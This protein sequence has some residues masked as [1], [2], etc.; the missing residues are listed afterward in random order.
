MS[1]GAVG[2]IGS[3]ATGQLQ[4]ARAAEGDRA[5]QEV[6]N[7]ARQSDSN[8]RAADAAGIG[9]TERE[10]E[11]SERDADGRRLWERQGKPKPQSNSP[12]VPAEADAPS[13]P[14]SKD[15]SGEAGTQ[16]DLS[17]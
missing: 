8:R 13:A 10:G 5:T 9:Q 11:A 2:T 16:I 15:P 3:V 17:G 7:Q 14:Q 6:A 4:Q 12:E 1:T